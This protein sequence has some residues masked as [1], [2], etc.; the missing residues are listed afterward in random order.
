MRILEDIELSHEFDQKITEDRKISKEMEVVMFNA[1][2]T[3]TA[4][5]VN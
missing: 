1:P 2:Q 5:L 3:R 4:C